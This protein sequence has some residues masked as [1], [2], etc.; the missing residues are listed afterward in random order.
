MEVRRTGTGNNRSF[1]MERA[2]PSRWR[3]GSCLSARF[4]PFRSSHVQASPLGARSQAASPPHPAWACAVRLSRCRSLNRLRATDKGDTPKRPSP[5]GP[6]RWGYTEELCVAPCVALGA[7]C[8]WF[9]WATLGPFSSSLLHAPGSELE[10]LAK[11]FVTLHRGLAVAA[12]CFLWHVDLF[13]LGWS[14]EEKLM[15]ICVTEVI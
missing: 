3:P 6:A 1:W 5:N 11:E 7:S 15:I 13:A 2:V 12:V 9:L 10:A 4:R 14:R 8:P